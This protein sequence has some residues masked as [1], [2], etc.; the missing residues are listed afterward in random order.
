MKEEKEDDSVPVE[1]VACEENVVASE[2]MEKSADAP[3][4][5]AGRHIYVVI[6]IQIIFF[7]LC[8]SRTSTT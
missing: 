4:T 1:D 6:P 7:H 3:G 8:R 2:E 5:S